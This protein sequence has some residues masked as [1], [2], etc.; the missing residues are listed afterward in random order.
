MLTQR[1][2]G[3]STC[4]SEAIVNWLLRTYEKALRRVLRHPAF[5]C[6]FFCHHCPQY[7]SASDHAQ[8][9]FPRAG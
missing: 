7:L 9:V 6:S 2:M 4:A 5:T 3:A 8:G 1:G